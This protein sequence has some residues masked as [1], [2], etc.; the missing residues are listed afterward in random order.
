MRLLAALLVL[1]SAP[2]LGADK[3]NLLSQEVLIES[4]GPLSS[5]PRSDTDKSTVYLGGILAKKDEEEYRKKIAAGAKPAEIE[6]PEKIYSVEVGESAPIPSGRVHLAFALKG[7]HL[8]EPALVRL[9]ESS[10]LALLFTQGENSAA[11]SCRK[12]GET[13]RS[14]SAYL[15]GRSIGWALSNDD[16]QSWTYQGVLVKNTESGDK[17]GPASPAIVLSRDE[18]WVYYMTG[19]QNFGQENLFR[20]RFSAGFAK[21]IG[22]PEAVKLSDF[23]VGLSL[24]NP[25]LVRL[26]CDPP[27]KLVLTLVGNLRS[28]NALPA[29]I[30]TDGLHFKLAAPT[31][32][33]EDGHLMTSPTQMPGPASV[34]EC[35][36]GELS[37]ILTQRELLHAEQI[38]PERWALKRSVV[39]F[40]LP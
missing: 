16:G 7:H 27:A 11:E 3:P 31:L 22:T 14:C 34:Q 29:Y 24:E 28:Q 8:N 5:H 10:Q 26:K 32:I 36:A 33:A 13:N 21:K 15:E 1:A 18:I 6:G 20:Q 17:S 9:P 40:L 23:T 35:Q 4:Y 19:R 37:G 30:S 38:A 12:K 2:A 25:H 39:R